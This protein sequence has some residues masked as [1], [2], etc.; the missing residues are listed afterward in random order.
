MFIISE[1]LFDHKK[2]EGQMPARKNIDTRR[3]KT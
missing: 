1:Q 3:D 2:K